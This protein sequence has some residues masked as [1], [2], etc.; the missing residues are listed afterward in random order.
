MVG[1]DAHD[2]LIEDGHWGR[3][4]E[5][6]PEGYEKVVARNPMGRLASPDEVAKVVAF[7]SSP[8]ASF[9]SGANWYV[10]GGSSN[11]VQF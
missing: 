7:I 3:V 8:A 9:V 5:R 10:D 6:D 11:H 4:R 1:L 2:T